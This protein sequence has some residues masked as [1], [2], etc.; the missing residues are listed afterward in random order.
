[1]LTQFNLNPQLASDTHLL[2]DTESSL[3]LL[4]NNASIPWIIIVP[5]TDETEVFD[6]PDAMQ[7]SINE[8]TKQIAQFFKQQFATEKM[9]IAAIG[10][11]VSQL[12]IH[13][14]G[15]KTGDACWPDVVWGNAYAF[16]DYSPQQIEEMRAA[17][18]MIPSIT[19]KELGYINE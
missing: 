16:S 13:V 2:L 1:M 15:R 3:I 12:H 17:L 10:N 9:N 18:L 7:K 6:L 4:H 5:K 19:I 11:I 14:I 8:M